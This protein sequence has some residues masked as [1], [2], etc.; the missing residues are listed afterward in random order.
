MPV[1]AG[2]IR[3]LTLD[4][5]TYDVMHDSNIKE[6]GSAYENSAIPTSGN[7]MRKMA[8]RVEMRES[9]IVAAGGADR[10]ALRALADR[11]TDFPISYMTA[12]GD[13][14]RTTG[15]IEFVARETEENRAELKLIPR[16]EW[17]S[18]LA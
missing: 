15:F 2:S 5:V 12:A 14:F 1:L 16:K 13:V 18:F 6:V 8:K 7:H 3:K 4:G 9:V 11:T 10:D 17:Q